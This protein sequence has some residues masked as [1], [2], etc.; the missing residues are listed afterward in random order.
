MILDNWSGMRSRFVK[1]FP[2]EYKRALKQLHEAR[3][4]PQKL[5][6]E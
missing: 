3:V 1:V 6:A 5:A 4:V 2:N